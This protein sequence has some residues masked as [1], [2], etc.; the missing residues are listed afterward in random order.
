MVADEECEEILSLDGESSPVRTARIEDSS[1]RWISRSMRKLLDFQ[2]PVL[3]ISAS[4][5]PE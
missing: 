5:S 1:A 3:R 2:P 4:V